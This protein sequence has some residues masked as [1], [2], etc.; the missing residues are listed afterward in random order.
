MGITDGQQLQ[1][2]NLHI[3]QLPDLIKVK[4]GK[5][6]LDPMIVAAVICQESEGKPWRSRYEPGFYRR[7]IER[8]KK[9]DL[10]GHVPDSIPT[11]NTEK[12]DRAKS[13]G[14]MQIMGETAR[15]MGYIED[16]ITM[17]LIPEINLEIGC[18]YLR[19]LLDIDART[20]IADHKATTIFFRNFFTDEILQMPEK[21]IRIMMALLRYN[22][23]GNPR[24]PFEVYERTHNGE[25]SKLLKITA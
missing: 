1:L 19:H 4:A 8:L 9:K 14:L 16:D 13:W 12:V 22:G 3:E 21:T 15:A 24:Y 23:G 25:A 5:F 6:Q 2:T 20:S 10:N 11:L 7:K 17:L 18:K